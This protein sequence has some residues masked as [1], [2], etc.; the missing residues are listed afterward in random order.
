M[1]LRLEKSQ[2]V[3]TGATPVVA[4]QASA[5][6]TVPAAVLHLDVV[7][8]GGACWLFLH[9]TL[10]STNILLLVLLLPPILTIIMSFS[11]DNN[12]GSIAH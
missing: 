6:V 8:A 2:S 5:G 7:L 9:L 4:I 1:D 10:G 3:C 12:H 11:L